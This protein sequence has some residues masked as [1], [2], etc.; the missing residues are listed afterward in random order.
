MK[1][2]TTFNFQLAKNVKNTVELKSLVHD[3]IP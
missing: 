2:M 3:S 1:L